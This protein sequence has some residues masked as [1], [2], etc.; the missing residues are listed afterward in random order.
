MLLLLVK[1]SLV[2]SN[3]VLYFEV[4]QLCYINLRIGPTLYNLKMEKKINRFGL[5]KFYNKL[6]RFLDDIEHN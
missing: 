2:T 6:D 1:T 4:A 3:R 5:I